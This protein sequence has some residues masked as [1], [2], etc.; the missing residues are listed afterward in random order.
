MWIAKWDVYKSL[1]VYERLSYTLP[2]LI[3]SW[4]WLSYSPLTTFIEEISAILS[5]ISLYHTKRNDYYNSW[6]AI[7]GLFIVILPNCVAIIIS[8]SGNADKGNCVYSY[9]NIVNWELFRAGFRYPLFVS[10][11]PDVSTNTSVDSPIG[12]G[13]NS[14]SREQ[15]GE[16]TR[17][18]AGLVVEVQTTK[19]QV[20]SSNPSSEEV[21]VIITFAHESWLAVIWLQSISGGDAVNPLDLLRHPWQKHV[22]LSVI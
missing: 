22:C 11:N 7:T 8:D 16:R 13:S 6:A 20:P 19:P 4:M 5:S 3:K 14:C 17:L 10:A 21:F 1:P 15:D 9:N 12:W 2:Y 18:T